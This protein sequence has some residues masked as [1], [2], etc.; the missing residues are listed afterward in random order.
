MLDQRRY[1]ELINYAY[2]LVNIE[3][4][5]AG[6]EF[7]RLLIDLTTNLDDLHIVFGRWVIINDDDDKTVELERGGI[8]KQLLTVTFCVFRSPTPSILPPRRGRCR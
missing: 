2:A 1:W 4:L 6:S 3:H 5:E 8:D 7:R